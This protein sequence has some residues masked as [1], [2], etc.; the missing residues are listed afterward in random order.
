MSYFRLALMSLV[1]LGGCQPRVPLE[2]R[3]PLPGS[4][5]VS[6]VQQDIKPYVGTFVRWGGVIVSVENRTDETWLEIVSKELDNDGKPLKNDVSLGRFLVRR[7]EFLDPAVYRPGREVTVYGVVK[8]L[9]TRKI[10]ERPYAYPV[11]RAE[12]LYL[13]P[14]Y[15]YYPYAYPYYPWPGYYYPYYYPYRFGYFPYW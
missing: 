8:A 15:R 12:R 14:E 6:I 4:P 10:G 9:V 3:E 13:W 7:E 5:S 1:L 11:V 2:I